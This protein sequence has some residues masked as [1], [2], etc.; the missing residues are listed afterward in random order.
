M[1]YSK[2]P[3][4]IHRKHHRLV[5][6]FFMSLLMSCVMSLVISILNVGFVDNILSVWLYACIVSFVI[7]FPATYFI[8]PIVDKLVEMTLDND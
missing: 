7:A 8:S 2:E 3:P 6:S 1:S 4:L 5:F